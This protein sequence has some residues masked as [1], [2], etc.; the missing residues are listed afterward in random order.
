MEPVE[1]CS[2]LVC[3]R[4]DQAGWFRS[5]E[6]RFRPSSSDKGLMIRIFVFVVFIWV[7]IANLEGLGFLQLCCSAVSFFLYLQSPVKNRKSGVRNLC[8]RSHSSND[9]DFLRVFGYGAAS[10]IP[11]HTWSILNDRPLVRFTCS[12]YHHSFHV[13][14]LFLKIAWQVF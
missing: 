6:S 7:I 9:D 11:Y 8:T 5:V 12:L 14:E 13:E 4:C 2:N 3:L 10:V 1:L